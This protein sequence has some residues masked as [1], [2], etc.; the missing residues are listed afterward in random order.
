MTDLLLVKDGKITIDKT[1]MQLVDEELD[2][3]GQGRIGSLYLRNRTNTITT[4][5]NGQSGFIS[6]E[7]LRIGALFIGSV[8]KVKKTQVRGQINFHDG[9]TI[10]QT[11]I[12]SNKVSAQN[13]MAYGNV[14]AA[15][16]KATGDISAVN[17]DAH[18]IKIIG[19]IKLV[20]AD[21]AE[22][23]DVVEDEIIDPGTV[24]IIGND[25]RLRPSE[26]PFDKRVAGVVSGGANYCPGLSS[27]QGH[28]IS[29]DCL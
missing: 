17:I 21:C 11:S 15:N 5:L 14:S 20:N 3:G 29:K 7:G 4:H 2:L 1:K 10:G 8:G 24:L 25:G 28:Q 18:D 23:F 16:I 9:L 6:A 22:E 27:I 13:F 19:D 12:D 26:K